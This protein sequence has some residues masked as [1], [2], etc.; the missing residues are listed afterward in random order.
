MFCFLRLVLVSLLTAACCAAAER[1]PQ[2]EQRATN[3]IA[4]L[5]A[6][7]ATGLVAEVVAAQQN[8]LRSPVP[9]RVDILELP[10][11]HYRYTHGRVGGG[12]KPAV[13]LQRVSGE[14]NLSKLDPL[15]STFWRRPTNIA[16]QNLGIG[17]GRSAG[18]EFG[19]G[20]WNYTAPKTSYGGHA[21]FEVEQGGTRIKVKFGELHSEPFAARIFHALGY[22]VAPADFAPAL[23]VRY[24]AAL[25]AEFN[26]R[27]PVNTRVT[28]FGVLPLGTIHFQPTH[29]PFRFITAAVLKNR[30]RITTE[31][32]RGWMRTNEA[33]IDYV[34]TGPANVQVKDERVK[35][36]GPWDFGQLG[37]EQLRETRAVGL[38][39]AWLGWFDAR[40]DNTRVKVSRDASGAP[41][42]KH[43]FTDLGGGLGKSTGWAGWHGEDAAKFPDVFTKPEIHQG[44][45]RMTVPF[46]VVNYRPIEPVRAFEEM[47]TNDGRWMARLIAQLRD[48]QI[49]DALRASGFTEQDVKVF[50]QKLFSRRD[51]MLR[52]LGL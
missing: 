33:M 11:V 16:A 43:F 6:L 34:I 24:D 1:A 14:T 45:G 17:F 7:G 49:V 51:R 42:V 18:P 10:F 32:L 48:E 44:R 31:E 29:D 27:K 30:A 39:A 40:F 13:N 26:S 52:D 41:E 3:L 9:A 4:E 19:A 47:T 22:N 8:N 15:P 28:A 23:K 38:L 20:V 21:G 36:I 25:F 35:S 46:R 12:E 2:H 50:A 5:R 37:H